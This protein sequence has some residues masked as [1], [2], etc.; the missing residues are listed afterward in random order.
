YRITVPIAPVTTEH[1]AS[2]TQSWYRVK[3]RLHEILEESGGLGLGNAS[4]QA[5]GARSLIGERFGLPDWLVHVGPM[6]YSIHGPDQASMPGGD[7][8]AAQLR[9]TDVV[10]RKQFPP[11][12]AAARRCHARA[13]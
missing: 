4:P 5:S 6:L 12:A 10:V 13:R 8:E 1:H 9:G 7:M 3:Y 11:P 2:T